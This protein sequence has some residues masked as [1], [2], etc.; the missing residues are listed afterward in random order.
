MQ[1]METIVQKAQ[2]NCPRMIFPE[3]D[4]LKILQVAQITK[5]NGVAN[6]ILLG[7]SVDIKRLAFNNGISLDGI[8]IADCNDQNR[9]ADFAERIAQEDPAFTVKMMMRNLRDPLYFAN[10]MVHFGEADSITAGFSYSTRE[11]ILCAQN[12]IGLE[13]GVNTKSSFNI[14]SIPGF[15]GSEGD[16][17]VFCDVGVCRNPSAEQ[18]ADIAI[19]TSDA[20]EALLGWEPRVALLS[21]STKGSGQGTEIDKVTSAVDII[22]QRR[23]FLKADGEFQ[24]DAALSLSAAAKKVKGES[25]VAGKA[26]IIVFPDL[27]AGNTNIKAVKLFANAYSLGP[28]LIGFKH[29]VSDLSR[30]ASLEH[31]IGTVAVAAALT[32]KHIFDGVS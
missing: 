17:L 32:K 31:L 28:I 29:Q 8:E 6:P 13:D 20:V 19:S 23:P 21:Y 25:E 27:N 14:V 24:L 22:K 30:T 5:E 10:C 16:T 15:K 18:L 3:T 12:I 11:V 7:N 2:K 9:K 26:N 1:F 4:E